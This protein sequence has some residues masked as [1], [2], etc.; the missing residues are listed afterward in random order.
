MNKGLFFKIFL[1]ILILLFLCSIGKILFFYLNTNNGISGVKKVLNPKYDK[2]TC[3]DKCNGIMS[4]KI[5]NN[6][7]KIDLYDYNVQKI[8]SYNT[9]INKNKEF[10]ERPISV[11]NKYYIT[12]KKDKYYVKNL[13]NKKIYTSKNELS[14]INENLI[15]IKN[16]DNYSILNNKGK[17][18]F[19]NIKSIKTFISNKYIQILI[20]NKSIL[21]DKMGN[22]LLDNYIVEKVIYDSIDIEKGLILKNMNNK[23]NYYLLDEDELSDEFDNYEIKGK[24]VIININ[25]DIYSLLPNGKFKK[26]SEEKEEKE[27]IKQIY[28]QDDIYILY[29]LKNQKL[30]EVDKEEYIDS[31]DLGC[32]YIRDNII[33]T[34]Y[35]EKGKIYTYELKENETLKSTSLSKLKPYKD[36]YFINN[37]SDKYIKINNFKSDNVK[38]INLSQI[39]TVKINNNK[40]IAYIIIKSKDKYGLYIA[41]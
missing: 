39:S 2:I 1:S 5:T 8:V 17:I 27:K 34:Y 3:I 25:D 30:D 4:V 10:I 38:R 12:Y 29:D 9:T 31:N 21:L 23:Y 6:N 15:Q 26:L 33:H 13:K 19:E 32:M 18:L 16:K 36:I 37:T 14:T 28:K 24:R 20:D 41:K 35:Y 40:N 11:T 7:Y 22:I